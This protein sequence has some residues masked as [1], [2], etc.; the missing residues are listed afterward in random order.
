M[1]G[2]AAWLGSLLHGGVLQLILCL[3][4]LAIF[5]QSIE[6]TLG[7]DRLAALMLAGGLVALAAQ[8]LAGGRQGAATLACAGVVA[9]VL[10]AYVTL[11][12]RAR[13][14][15]VLFAPWFSTVLAVP[16]TALIACWLAL[17][18]PLGLGLDEPLA[19]IGGGWFAHLAA[20]G[21][22]AALALALSRP[23]LMRTRPA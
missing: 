11:R 4:A 9:S 17:Q 13:V 15:C 2:A 22:G 19:S 8:L 1:L 21:A 6:D 16:A 7:R 23:P 3:A 12:P 10:G 5:G 20:I 18:V 14:H